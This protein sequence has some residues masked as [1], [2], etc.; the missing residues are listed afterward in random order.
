MSHNVGMDWIRLHKRMA[1]YHRD[2][3]DCVWCQMMFPLPEN[4]YGLSIDHVDPFGG[5]EPENLVTCCRWCN[6]AKLDFSLHKWT[7]RLNWMYG[8]LRAEVLER[9]RVQVAKPLDMQE[10]YRLAKLRR[11]NYPVKGRWEYDYSSR[12]AQQRRVV[13][14]SAV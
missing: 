6:S 1:I 3:F 11:P 14:S 4:G 10:G 12:I 8:V 5:N 2:E 9:V 7:E 13:R